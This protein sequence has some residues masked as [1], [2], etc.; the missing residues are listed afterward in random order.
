MK[1][2]LDLH[3]HSEKSPDGCM[4][5]ADIVKT[6]RTHGLN[7][8]AVCDHDVSLESAPLYEDFIVIP[9]VEVSTERGHVLGLFVTEQIST[10]QFDEAIR[11]IHEQGGIAVIAHPFEHSVNA[12]R[13]DDVI[14]MLDGVEAWNGRADRKN[15]QANSMAL[16]LAQRC[17]KIVTAGSDAHLPQEIGN[18][19]VVLEV[20]NLT[21]SDV[22]ESIYRGAEQIQGRRGES[23]CVAKSQ[24]KKRI[25]TKAGILSYCKWLLFAVKCAMEDLIREREDIHVIDS[26]NRK[27]GKENN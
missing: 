9:G 16:E 14:D 25:K 19:A 20:D 26:E 6:A 15:R 27:K 17:G 10:K 13:L 22:K 11:L 1:I 5:I 8:V 2:K 21:L 12:S 7:G 23:L 4:T 24:L 18:G 3:V